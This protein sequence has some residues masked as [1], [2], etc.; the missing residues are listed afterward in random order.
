LLKG[1]RSQEIIGKHFSI[2][3]S[4]NNIIAEK[5]RK[6]LEISLQ[7]GKVEDKSWQYHKDRKRFFANVKITC[8]IQNSVHIDFSKVTHDL[9]DFEVIT[10]NKSVP[11]PLNLGRGP[12]II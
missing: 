2:F 3:Y 8:L 9:T 1:Y 7:D 11:Q 10:V 6:E 5:P 12:Q 4:N